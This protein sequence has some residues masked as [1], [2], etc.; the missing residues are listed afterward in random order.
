[1]IV[2]AVGISIT[3]DHKWLNSAIE[4]LNLVIAAFAIVVFFFTCFGIWEPVSQ[5]PLIRLYTGSPCYFSVLFHLPVDFPL[6][7]VFSF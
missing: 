7:I 2:F 1:M 5:V 6:V 3:N 4:L